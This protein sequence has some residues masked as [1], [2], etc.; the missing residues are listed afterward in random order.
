LR[1][2]PAS[3]TYRPTLIRCLSINTHP[4]LHRVVPTGIQVL[5]ASSWFKLP[6]FFNEPTLASRFASW[7]M[8]CSSARSSA[9]MRRACA[10]RMSGAAS[11]LTELMRR[12]RLH[13]CALASVSCSIC[14]GYTT[15][16]TCVLLLT[17]P[18]VRQHLLALLQQIGFPAPS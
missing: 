3:C 1:N 2:A 15:T 14:K 18:Q 10:C 13:L 11:L 7:V 12:L 9:V 8:R 5:G 4:P 16:H 17:V 6:V